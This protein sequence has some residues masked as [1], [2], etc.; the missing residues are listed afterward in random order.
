[1]GEENATPKRKYRA[2]KRRE[3]WSSEEHRR[4]LEALEEYG[5]DW[6]KITQY[7]M[8]KSRVQVRS[9]AQKHF[10][11]LEKMQNQ[12][13]RG[14]PPGSPVTPVLEQPK[15]NQSMEKPMETLPLDQIG[16]VSETSAPGD[17]EPPVDAG[18]FHTDNLYSTPD[19]LFTSMVSGQESAS[20]DQPSQP[21]QEANVSQPRPSRAA[22][23]T[24]NLTRVHLVLIAD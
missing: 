23:N 22:H 1:M 21:D 3:K 6:M 24:R 11:K 5:R 16:E 13:G 20:F 15:L 14:P 17:A 10:L 2:L 7:V 4:F 8:T 18:F 9:H 12:N 19:V